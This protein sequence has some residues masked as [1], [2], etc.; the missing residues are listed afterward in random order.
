MCY[1]V[2]H[3]KV[4]ISQQRSNARALGEPG[5]ERERVAGGRG[6][7]LEKESNSVYT[8]PNIIWMIKS[9]MSRWETRV[10]RASGGGGRYRILT[11]KQGERDHVQCI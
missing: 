4:V 1:F 10:A 9:R 6:K 5:P 3:V 8:S 11:G 7:F 2:W